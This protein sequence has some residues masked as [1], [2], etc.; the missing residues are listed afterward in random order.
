MF[1]LHIFDL[2]ICEIELVRK[3]KKKQKTKKIQVTFQISTMFAFLIFNH[4]KHYLL[5]HVLVISQCRRK[6]RGN[7][8][9]LSF[10]FFW[11]LGEARDWESIPSVV[12]WDSTE[13]SLRLR[14]M[15][16]TPTE[17]LV[18]IYCFS[19][20]VNNSPFVGSYSSF[21]SCSK[22]YQKR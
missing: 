4:H 11:V 2:H 13:F 17:L 15:L 22:I 12:H 8:K 1:P 6:G 16:S 7:K 20:V 18:F 19:F 10:F 14:L 9:V 21:V 3:R 5:F